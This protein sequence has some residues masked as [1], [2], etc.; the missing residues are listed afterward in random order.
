MSERVFGIDFGTTNSLAAVVVGNEMRVLTSK[1]DDKPHPSVVWYRGSDVI[2][3]REARTYLES[4]DGGVQH[5]FIRSP[6]MKLRREGPVHIPGKSID[7]QDIVAEVLRYIRYDAT[8]RDEVGHDISRAVMTIPV[9]FAGT[10]RSAL[11]AAARKAGIG[12][13]QFVHEPISALYAYLRSRS[14]FNRELA[15]LEN[16]VA[17]VFDWGGGTLDLTVC[18]IVSGTV[19]QIASRGNNEVGGDRFD[20]RLR[21]DVKDRFAQQHSLQ[22]VAA[23]EQPGVSAKLL[24]QCE[25]AKIYLSSGDSFSLIIKDY[26]RRDGP[27]RNLA[28]DVTRQHLEDL[29]TD[30]V[31][32]GLAEIDQLLEESLL[33]RR[34]IELCIATGG[35]VNMPAIWH[36]L[37]ERF[38]TRVPPLGNRDRIIAE[39]AAWI[40]H[41]GRRLTLAKPLELLVSDGRGRG[42]SLPLVDA[43]QTL[44]VENERIAVDSR[45]FFCVD[46]RDGNAVFEFTK[47]RKVGLLQSA[48]ERTTLISLNLPV[49]P[50]ARPFRER[51]ECEIQIDHDYIAHVSLTSK[52]RGEIVKGEIHDLDFGLA[53]PKVGDSSDMSSDG[54]VDQFDGK[55]E[56]QDQAST[57]HTVVGRH[58]V[59]LRPNISPTENWRL[60][61][62]DLVIEWKEDFL[63]KRSRE[64]T[65]IQHE[66]QM[67]YKPCSRCHRT[68][69]QIKTQVPVDACYRFNCS[70][71]ERKT[72]P[73]RG[74]VPSPSSQ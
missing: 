46:P 42:K 57:N 67:Y 63:D 18:R 37:V 24:T 72:T 73:S 9:D 28:V 62:G 10:Q 2:V 12:V 49:D 65:E 15:E 60:V 39:G 56:D 5:G 52:G 35:M 25:Q 7:P 66:E 21:N 53:L 48:D 50:D 68:E 33:D 8:S 4:L 38:G 27:E 58:N 26:L 32:R 29:S 64:A 13:L 11:R 70:E 45:R 14:D 30:L 6:K 1:N 22:D 16:R 41:D 34:D 74:S 23:L 3:G 71:V 36:G 69:Y 20:E 40:A 17:L 44:P 59:A 55:R 47:P 31:K 61:P 51:L 19:M 43:T 54:G